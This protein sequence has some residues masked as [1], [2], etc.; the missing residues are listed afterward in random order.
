MPSYTP[1]KL[2]KLAKIKITKFPKHVFLP[3]YI[4]KNKHNETIGFLMNKADGKPIQY[5]L[6]DSKSRYKH[7]PNITDKD[8]A[9]LCINFLRCICE[10][11]KKNI[12]IGDINTQNILFDTDCNIYFIDCDSYQVENFPCP[13]TTEAF[14]HPAHRGKDMKEFMRNFADEY[15]AVAIFLFMLINL[16]QHP[17]NCKGG[18]RDNASKNM[19]FPY[20]INGSSNNAPNDIA[21]QRWDRL[22]NGLK[23]CF[24][25]S[26]QKGGKYASENK[27]LKPEIWLKHFQDFER[28]L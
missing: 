4:L 10:L 15:Y 24:Y 23:E 3:L 26:F 27:C 9:K 1:H 28:T 14:L 7:F 6:G 18:G 21:K 19:K 2:E 16:G 17:Y 22:S 13:V 12:I 20:D 5:I 8:L 25:H 11:H